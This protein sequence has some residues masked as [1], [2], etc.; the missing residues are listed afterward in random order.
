MDVWC[1]ATSYENINP[2]ILPSNT[3]PQQSVNTLME[4]NLTK[5]A[6]LLQANGAPYKVSTVLVKTQTYPGITP[7][8]DAKGKVAM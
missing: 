2:K 1:Q 5:L 8:V 6:A 4:I 3:P 7:V